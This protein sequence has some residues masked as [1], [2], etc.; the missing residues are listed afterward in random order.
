MRVRRRVRVR[1]RVRVT[2]SGRIRGRMKARMRVIIGMRVMIRVRISV[3]ARM[4]VRNRVR[5][6]NILTSLLSYVCTYNPNFTECKYMH[7]CTYRE[8]ST[9]IFVLKSDPSES[10]FL[11]KFS[12]LISSPC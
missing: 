11:T 3:P 12:L 5:I 1:V 4:R 2:N 9:V 7:T 10:P 6:E 8:T